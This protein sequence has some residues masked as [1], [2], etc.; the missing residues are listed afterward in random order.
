MPRWRGSWE[1]NNVM[2][3]KDGSRG[4]ETVKTSTEARAKEAIKDK[5]S[6]RLFGTTMMQ[7]YIEVRNLTKE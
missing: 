4:T 1:F 6:M 2:S 5:A 7:G 3:S